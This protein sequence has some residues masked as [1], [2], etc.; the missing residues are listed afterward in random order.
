MKLGVGQM[1]EC[2]YE[3]SYNM[4][5]LNTEFL[6]TMSKSIKL[7]K[8]TFLILMYQG[9][10]ACTTLSQ[11]QDLPDFPLFDPSG[12]GKDIQVTQI[13]TSQ[14]NDAP[15]VMLTAWTIKENEMSLVGLTV[16]GQEIL[17]LQFDGKTLTEEYSPLLSSPIN[18]RLVISQI[19]LSY[20]PLENI[21]QK[22]AKGLW[23]LDQDKEQRHITFNGQSVT[24][25]KAKSSSIPPEIF[26]QYWP[27]LLL[28]SPGLDQ[29]LTI[30]TI[31]A[32]NEQ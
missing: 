16:T 22:L 25:I 4:L 17:R 30:K 10:V 8:F 29:N 12:F 32:K 24:T 2:Y 3:T 27:E 18:G 1:L 20:W 26:N 13:V 19:Q 9:I 21:Q 31:S 28:T 14:V 23:Q 5:N 7:I 11:V 15:Q 6:A